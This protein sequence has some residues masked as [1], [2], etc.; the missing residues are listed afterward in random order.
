[1]K[2][3]RCARMVSRLALA[4]FLSAGAGLSAQGT[5]A[6]A[7]P[8][9]PMPVHPGIWPA[10]RSPIGL[11][12]AIEARIGDIIRQMTLEEKVG[13]TLQPEIRW[14]TPEE[15]RDYH[16]GSIE[17]GGGSFPRGNKHASVGDWVE[18]IQSYWEAS[19]DPRANH[20]RI[21]L[22]WA[23]DAVHGHNNVLGATLF[24]HNIGL[25]AAHDPDLIRRIG[26]VTAAEVRSTGMDWAFAPTIAVARDDRWGRTYESYSEDPRIV[27]RYAA[28]IVEGLEGSGR[29]FL[30]RD[31]VLATA[32]HFLGDGSTDK[33]RDQGNSLVSEEE[34]SRVDAAGYVTAIGAGAQTVMASYSSWHGTKMHANKALLTDVL[35]T[36]M[37]FD[38]L[39]IGDWNGHSQIPGCTLSDCAIAFN[40]GVDVFNVPTDWKALYHNMIRQVRSGEIPMAR[41]DDAVR[42]V[43]RVKFRAGI[44]DGTA[45]RD[46]PGTLRPIGTAEH[47]AVA[48]E[49]VRKSLVM[50]K[51][52]GSLL[53]IRPGARI[54]VAGEGADNVAM[55]TG[56]WTLSW[57]G[58]DNG[59]AEFPGATS[60]Y[61]GIRQAA[62]AAGGTAELAPDGAFARKPDVAIVVFGETPYA[63]YMGDQTDVALHHGNNESLALLKRL[64][65]AGIPTV[66]VLLSGRPLYVNPQI[67][68]ADAFV[69]AFLPG[70]EGAGVADVLIAG[71][72]GKPRHDFTG[73]LSFSWP[74]RPDQTPLNI[75]DADYDPQFAYG[76]GL[77]Y[78]APAKTPRLPEVETSVQYGD[79]GVYFARGVFWNGYGLTLGAA[80]APPVAYAGKPAG[81]GAVTA[82]PSPRD[83]LV[84]HLG[85]NGK[86]E[87]WVAIAA[88]DPTDI[89]REANGSML[90]SLDVKVGKAP[91]SAVHLMVGDTALPIARLLRP[92]ASHLE[93]A[94]PCFKGQD[95]SKVQ[96]LLRLKTGGTLDMDLIDARLVENKTGTVCP[97]E[98]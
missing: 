73:R 29:A 27:S 47:R 1:M 10:A 38:G 80:G 75:G 15:V 90:V 74:K 5:Q 66:A 7:A 61:Q 56:G 24:P 43:L 88:A 20:V 64:K 3:G 32:K 81:A 6:P 33:G 42:R 63:E 44:M 84:V 60:I 2:A 94:L 68:Q 21:P 98:E 39:I 13:Q 19:V 78:A 95:F 62:E 93:I 14:I 53:P 4:A 11:D 59:P 72:D 17:N 50:L 22:M 28:A 40:A 26:A 86:G 70:S 16:I 83:P 82:G 18:M 52:N 91:S 12:P 41:L 31:H 30:D 48:R 79:R 35:K 54:L 46:R 25:G 96:P 55:Q 97:A 92:G 49:A 67:N 65:A 23:S 69:A 77:T 45:P 85:W 76:F 71:A 36:R 51:N 9:E 58:N 34:L 37:G 8:S 89:S 57:Q 87:G